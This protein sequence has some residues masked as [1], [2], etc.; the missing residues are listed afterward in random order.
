MLARQR[1]VPDWRHSGHRWIGGSRDGRARLGF[2]GGELFADSRP[3]P[4]A[5]CGAMVIGSRH[6]GGCGF[7]SVV[8]QA[9]GRAVIGFMSGNQQHPDMM[10]EVFILAPTDLLDEHEIP[11]NGRASPPG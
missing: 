10:C 5:E 7:S 3:D 11:S 4:S 2:L 6:R 8:E 9:T 1:D